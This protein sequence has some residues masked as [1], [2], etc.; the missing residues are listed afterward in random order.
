MFNNKINLIITLII[1]NFVWCKDFI[2]SEKKQ[3]KNI[4]L[5][6]YYS[7]TISEKQ[8]YASHNIFNNLFLIVKNTINGEEF[9]AAQYNTKKES[10]I[11]FLVPSQNINFGLSNIFNDYYSFPYWNF[12]NCYNCSGFYLFK[13]TDKEFKLLGIYQGYK[14][15]DND[16]ISDLYKIIKIKEGKNRAENVYLQIKLYLTNNILTNY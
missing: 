13:I 16:G 11:L 6:D 3:E 15:I 8:I 14:D 10:K 12:G 5:L 9:Y 2:N 7:N 4:K 1:L